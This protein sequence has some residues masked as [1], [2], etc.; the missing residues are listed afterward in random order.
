MTARLPVMVL[1]GTSA[2]R[3]GWTRGR[4]QTKGRRV[5]VHFLDV[6]WPKN[7]RSI[8]A[9]NLRIATISELA[10]RLPVQP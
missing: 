5:L 6:S 10:A 8:R 1:A 2:G 7:F 4:D 3:V 9:S